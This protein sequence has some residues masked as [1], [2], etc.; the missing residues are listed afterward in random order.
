MPGAIARDIR[1]SLCSRISLTASQNP[2]MPRSATPVKWAQA[3]LF[4]PLYLTCHDIRA[5]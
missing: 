4:G 1:S 5:S 2:S 3:L